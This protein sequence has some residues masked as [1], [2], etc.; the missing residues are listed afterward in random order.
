MSE[1]ED[2]KGSQT[3]S[4]AL[5]DAAAGDAANDAAASD[6]PK[7]KSSRRSSFIKAFKN[8]FSSHVENYTEAGTKGVSR[9]YTKLEKEVMGM[10][11]QAQ[12]VVNDLPEKTTDDE[13]ED[14]PDMEIFTPD[15]I[16]NAVFCGHLVTDLDSIGGAIAAAKLYGGTP[17]AASD[18]NSETKYALERFGVPVPRKI[19]DIIAEDPDVNICLV[20]HQ[21]SSQMN[22]SIQAKNV[23]GII[24]HHALQNKTLVTQK[25][26][27]VDIRPW[28]SMCTIIAHSYLIRKKRPSKA[29][30][31]IML[32]AILSDT[33]N[34]NGPTTT[35]W[36]RLIV[37]ILAELSEIEDINELAK[38][39]FHAKSKELKN[40]SAFSLVHGDKKTFS[41]DQP[42][43]FNGELG[44]AVIETTDDEAI[45]KRVEEL[46]EE[47][48]A[49]KK[50]NSLSLLFVAIVNIVNLHSNLVLCGP[51]ETSI[52]KEAFGDGI[53]SGDKKTLLDIGERVSRKKEFIP[54]LA[55]A[56][57]EGWKWDP[58]IGN[59]FLDADEAD[60][61]VHGEL[62]IPLSDPFGQIQRIGSMRRVI[63]ISTAE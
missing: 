16:R 26:I 17:A 42:G 44:F 21:Q 27:Y 32:C 3:S 31:G 8:D 23:V 63:T 5:N 37:T 14:L 55:S 12:S 1:Y 22:P 6:N 48:I 24:D 45:L 15:S 28:G 52:A 33:L 39:Q 9:M 30:A 41:F 18:I 19:E 11:D 10:L 7:K 25:P 61:E 53:V 58:E 34:L 20:D 29:I 4:I 43:G 54:S 49:S 59:E 62:E 50:E 46:V 40:L 13:E 47:M 36:D 35:D 51:A 56:I 60:D 57:H 2:A 38:K